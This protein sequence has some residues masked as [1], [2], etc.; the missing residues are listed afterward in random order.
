MF[1][2]VCA[3]QFQ[4]QTLLTNNVALE[5]ALKRIRGNRFSCP[6]RKVDIMKCNKVWDNYDDSYTDAYSDHQNYDS[7]NDDAFGW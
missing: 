6:T 4:G 1:N 7:N 5:G 3:N 2:G